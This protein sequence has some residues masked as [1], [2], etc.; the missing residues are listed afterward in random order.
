MMK[1]FKK[2]GF[3][4]VEIMVVVAVIGLLL[5]LAIPYGLKSRNETQ[6]RL[7]EQEL[8]VTS[9]MFTLCNMAEGKFPETADAGQVPK[10]ML[11]YLRGY[12]WTEETV[13]GGHWK[14]GLD[15]HGVK[16]SISIVNPDKDADFMKRI[17]RSI[18]DG[19]LSTGSFRTLDGSSGYIYIVEK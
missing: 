19:N 1:E 7:I 10:G 9:G 2:S 3:T 11:P 13:I 5:A 8:R 4:L 14:W 17:D 6:R 16:A 18:D 12:P 15:D